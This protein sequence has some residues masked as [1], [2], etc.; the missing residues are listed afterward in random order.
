MVLRIGLFALVFSL[1]IY[2]LIDASRT[3]PESVNV[4]PKWLWIAFIIF[5]PLAGALLWILIGRA[6]RD[7]GPSGKVDRRP[8]SPDDDPDFLRRLNEDAQRAKRER[9]RRTQG[10][11]PEEAR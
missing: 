3:S 11:G 6:G 5:V 9:E 2:A 8:V 4:L 10:D 7:A 1:S